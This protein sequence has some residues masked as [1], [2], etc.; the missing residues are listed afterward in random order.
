[1]VAHENNASDLLAFL[2]ELDPRPM[3]GLLGL[4][5]GP[6]TCQREVQAR[7]AGKG[8]LDLVIR[9]QADGQPNAAWPAGEA[10]GMLR[11]WDQEADGIIGDATGWYVSDL[12]SRRTANAIDARLARAYQDGSEA[13][14]Y[15]TSGGNPMFVA[16][17]RHPRGSDKAWIAVDVRCKGRGDP[18]RAWL[19]R[20]CVPRSPS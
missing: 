15:R 3:T 13:R 7:G 8:R 10:A 16:W 6:Y 9:R 20:P 2:F 18:S 19:V 5:D 1:L 11:A 17:G 12:V 4:E 14:A